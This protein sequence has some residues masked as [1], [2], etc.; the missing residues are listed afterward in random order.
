[1][2]KVLVTGGAGFIG[3][4]FVDYLLKE[5]DFEIVVL[6]GLT[7]AGNLNRI[8]GLESYQAN[9]D[10]VRFVYHNLRSP[11]NEM[12]A[13]KIGLVE[14]IVHM[15]ANSSVEDTLRNPEASVLDNVLSTVHVLDFART[16]RLCTREFQQ[17]NLKLILY[18]STDEVYGPAPEGVDFDENA[19]HRPSNP[20]SAGKAGGEDYAYAFHV[21]FGVPVCISNQ[22]NVF[23]FDQHPEKFIPTV[24]R[25]VEEGKTLPVYSNPDKT[26]AG[27][28]FWI[29]SYDV[30]DATLFILR[31]GIPGEKYHVVGTER[32]NL[33]LAQ[34]I[35]KTMGKEL[36]YEMKDFHSS[37][38]GH[39]MRYGM[40]DTKLSVMG[41]KL[42][43][44]LE[45]AFKRIIPT[46][47][48]K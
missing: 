33:E 1:M 13:K 23:G 20:Y 4:Q 18:F 2:T 28:R 35:A 9:P 34:D 12:V 3:H 15:A 10:R 42:K 43:Y 41:F 22:M 24:I 17:T 29:F 31:N 5:T 40:K 11:I 37:R 8:T 21:S 25:S 39:D 27:S 16:D 36:V 7:Y 45:E 38:P 47:L 44:G 14:Y 6:D 30:A 26:K 46:Y 19:P 32:D 48:K